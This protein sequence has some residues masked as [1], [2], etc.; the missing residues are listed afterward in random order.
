MKEEQYHDDPLLL[1]SKYLNE[2]ATA[3]E[4]AEL[5]AWVLA[6][7]E[8]RAQFREVQRAWAL[9]GTSENRLGVDAEQEWEKIKP[10][11]QSNARVVALPR[12]RTWWRVA[13]VAA[14][15]VLIFSAY[16]LLGP[17]ATSEL[18]LAAA[19]QIEAERLPDGS[20]VTLNQFA[21]VRY[22]EAAGQRRG[23][24]AGDAFFDVQRDTE[25]PFLITT[26]VLTVEVL[27]TSFY[28]DARTAAG[29]TQ[30]VVQSGRVAVRTAER[31]M[32][33]EAGE[34]AIY[35]KARRNLRKAADA[36]PYAL[37]WQSD[38]LVFDA[39]PLDRVVLALQRKFHRP[40]ALRNPQL[41]RCKLTTDLTGLDLEAI[42][43]ILAA[44]LQLEVQREGE[45][46]WLDGNPDNC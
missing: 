28:V 7:P 26:D 43:R 15:V 34:M 27:G 32:V 17:T 14:A 16:W 9:A 8:N 1:I 46:V 39:T 30:V 3:A 29:E 4:V 42:L 12:R 10:L 25:R 11:I 19:A 31:E 21:Q 45:K 23:E 36:D 2:E 18:A 33:L 13:S 38:S 37:A 41:V 35:D 22:R 24:L 5:E 20:Q 44:T 6:S 40:I